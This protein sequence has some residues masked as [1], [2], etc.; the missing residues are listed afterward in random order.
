M[1]KT[2]IFYAVVL[3]L[4][5]LSSEQIYAKK[6]KTKS[7]DIVPNVSE[8]LKESN[9]RTL[10]RKVA[11]AR[12][13]NET[14]SGA[15]F[16]INSDGDRIGK[17][18]SDILSAKLT[19][20][21]KFLMFERTDKEKID[22][23]QA[24]ADLKSDGVS[25]DYLIVGSVS[26]FG[27]T[28]ESKVGVF[29]RKKTQ[30]AYAKVNVRLI[31]TSNGRIIY[32][33]EGAGEAFSSARTVAGVGGKSGYDS[34]L[35]DQ[36]MSEAISQMVSNIVENLT[37]KPWRTYILSEE[38]G[39]YIISGGNSQGIYPNDIF[40]VYSKGRKM[41]NPQTGLLIELPGKK[42]AEIVIISSYGDDEFSEISFAKLISG[43]I[44]GAFENYFVSD[45]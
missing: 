40:S 30:K 35:D 20:T 21:E 32:S 1:K 36:A 45:K 3:T 12:F 23:E 22:D 10:K 11:I 7:L 16:F 28:N 18:A 44:D 13:S 26:E 2:L 39:Q 25:V 5:L 4:S 33:E 14:K 15:S 27:R 41:K 42:V 43:S 29:S 38:D 24:L 37:N 6:D 34:T 19:A 9:Q 31:D 8:S 17:Q